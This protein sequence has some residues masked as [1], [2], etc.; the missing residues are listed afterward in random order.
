[1]DALVSYAAEHPAA[2]AVGSK[3]LYPNKTIQHAGVVIRYDRWPR[4]VYTGFPADHPAVNKSRRFQ[5]VT[6]ASILIRRPVF[7]EVGGF[8]TVFMN[9]YEDVDLCL[10]LGLRGYEVHYCHHSVLYHLESITREHR[11]QEDERNAQTYLRRWFPRVQPDE[12]DYYRADGLLTLEYG[13]TY[14]LAITISPLLALVNG[15][16]RA[17]RA[18][19]LWE[20]R[21]QQV[22]D[23]LRENI[24]LNV[25]LQEAA[26]REA[27]QGRSD[28]YRNGRPAEVVPETP[29]FQPSPAREE[30][31]RA[32]F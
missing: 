30:V 11:V 19:R 20:T 6:A 25:S 29:G 7:K 1:L 24:R 3:L 15:Q 21:N 14:P 5:S 27:I 8:D 9:G 16:N 28:L 13:G 10:R 18:A 4:H 31:L 17:Q 12:L 32:G 22:F 26:L 2:A 23:L